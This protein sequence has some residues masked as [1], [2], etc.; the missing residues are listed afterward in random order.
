MS[1]L[2]DLRGFKYALEPLAQQAQWKLDALQLV[3]ARA[4]QQLSECKIILNQLHTQK[5]AVLVAVKE[6][7]KSRLDL[8]TYTHALDFIQSLQKKIETQQLEVDEKR[9]QLDEAMNACTVQQQKLEL[10]ATHR[11]ENLEEFSLEQGN[12][13]SAEADRDWNARRFLRQQQEKNKEL[14]R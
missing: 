12:I 7:W 9:K 6:L 5:E 8:T 14:K 4:Q 13:L 3:L 2:V 1:S 10:L 11:Q